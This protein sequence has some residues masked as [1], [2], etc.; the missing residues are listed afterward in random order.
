MFKFLPLLWA[1]LQRKKLRTW[2]TL[3]SIMIA[4][5]LFGMLQT[6]GTAMTGGAQVAGADRMLTT[7]KMSLVLSMPQSYVNKVRA[8][9]GVEV[10]CLHNWFGGVAKKKDGEELQ[11][12]AF[13]VDAASFVETYPE[14][15]LTAAE[16]RDFVSDRATALVG[17]SLARQFGWKV[18]DT[19]PLRS[20]TWVRSEGGN[21]WNVRIAGI[22][23]ANN[24]SL[25]LHYEYFNEARSVAKDSIGWMV[26]RI[27]EPQRAEQIGRDIDALFANSSTETKTAT[28]R[29]FAQSFA[30]QVG[31]IGA[32]VAA[33]ATAVFFTMLLVTANTMAEAVRER[34]SELGVLKTLGYSNIGVTLLVLSEALIL[35]LLG[36]ALG[37]GFADAGSLL[38]GLVRPDMFPS[39]G[40]PVQTYGS[41]AAVAI[42]LGL[43]AAVLPCVRTWRLRITDALRKI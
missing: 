8:V 18:G 41:G 26:L 29:A 4:F 36:A 31:D 11:I 13:A 27:A 1:N 9:P 17:S 35:T 14:F 19:I 12:P 21:A 24:P 23:E 22:Y 28:E 30:N 42:I 20:N 16:R 5:L 25:Y 43:L 39:T 15:T 37:L 33:V 40:M 2:L 7:H 34:T 32:I 10:V 38:L 3:A 6:L